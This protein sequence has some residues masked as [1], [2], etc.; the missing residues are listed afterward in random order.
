VVMSPT[1]GA[2]AIRAQ[3]R[4]AGLSQPDVKMFG[5]VDSRR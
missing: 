5:I 3:E 1:S 2:V 4:R